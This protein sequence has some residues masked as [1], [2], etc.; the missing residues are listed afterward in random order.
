MPSCFQQ[1]EGESNRFQIYPE[2]SVLLNKAN[3]QGKLIYKS[4]IYWGFTKA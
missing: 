2:F 1:R 4:Q 3:P